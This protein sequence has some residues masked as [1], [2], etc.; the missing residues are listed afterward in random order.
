MKF[1]AGSILVSLLLMVCKNVWSQAKI[2]TIVPKQTITVGTAFQVQYIIYNTT[3]LQELKAPDFGQNFRL[4]NGPSLYQGTV[5]I[6]NVQTP[7][8]NFSY[9]LVPLQ[10]GKLLIEGA[11]AIYKNETVKSND[12]FV[13]VSDAINNSTPYQN[14]IVNVPLFTPESKKE[15]EATIEKDLF[16]RTSVN[17]KECFVGEPIVATFQLFSRLSSSSEV[18]KNPGFY[19]FSIVDMPEVIEQQQTIAHVNGIV[20]NTHLL[21]K[22][23]LYPMQAGKLVIDEM[24]TGNTIEYKDAANNQQKSIQKILTS[25]PIIITVKPLPIQKHSNNFSGAVG[26][27]VINAEL[28]GDTIQQNQIGKLRITLKGNGNFLQIEAPEINWPEGVEGFEPSVKEKFQN[29]QAPTLGIRQYEYTFTADSAGAYFIPPVLFTFFNP[30]NKQYK[31]VTSDS[32]QIRVIPVD[33]T[34]HAIPF[35]KEKKRWNN[36]SWLL[37]LIALTVVLIIAIMAR[38]KKG[39]KQETGLSTEKLLTYEEKLKA[40]D[41]SVMTSKEAYNQLLITLLEF[42]KE[43]YQL[44]Y[45]SKAAVI[46]QLEK[47]RLHQDEITK[48][49]FIINECELVQ[50]YSAQPYISFNELKQ[51]AIDLVHQLEK[52][53]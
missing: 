17:K 10:K 24:H 37:L 49:V 47:V 25:K 48:L 3:D 13:L 43:N 44:N 28:A 34:K 35:S 18:I 12:A 5:T 32:F 23:Q 19:G 33:Q 9:T 22:V 6:N 39:I 7:I 31:T 20:Y 41:A 16:I 50:Y 46:Q 8:Q 42:F 2:E 30:Y 15:L 52:K 21:R 1:F 38:K 51:Q 40:I 14:R 36:Q 4:V 27:F 53:L 26:D 11:V 29:E 45:S